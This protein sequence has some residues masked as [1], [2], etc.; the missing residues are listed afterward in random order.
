VKGGLRHDPV[1][2]SRCGYAVDESIAL[3]EASMGFR[4]CRDV[5]APP[6]SPPSVDGAT[7]PTP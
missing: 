7:L 4:C 5:D 3:K 2:G 1:R 6:V